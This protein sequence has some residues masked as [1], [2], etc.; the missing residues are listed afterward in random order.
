[1]QLTAD[2]LWIEHDSNFRN[3]DLVRVF[4]KYFNVYWLI[5]LIT[6]L[7]NIFNIFW[8]TYIKNIFLNDGMHH[9]ADEEIKK[10]GTSIFPAIG[11]TY[12][13]Q[14]LTCCNILLTGYIVMNSN[15]HICKRWCYLKRRWGKKRKILNFRELKK[16]KPPEVQ[17]ALVRKMRMKINDDKRRQRQPVNVK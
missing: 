9:N 4:F 15:K 2:F 8:L 16:P 13:L 5:Y 7:T 6:V 10:Y 14:C 11:V 12:Y 1:M 17:Q 3:H